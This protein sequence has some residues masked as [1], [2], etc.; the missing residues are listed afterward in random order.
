MDTTWKV[1]SSWKVLKVRP[2]QAKFYDMFTDLGTSNIGA[3]SKAIELTKTIDDIFYYEPSYKV[4][5][6]KYHGLAVVGIN[7]QLKDAYNLRKKIVSHLLTLLP[8]WP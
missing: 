1:E 6:C 5:I 7:A 8:D 3:I 2:F 4:L